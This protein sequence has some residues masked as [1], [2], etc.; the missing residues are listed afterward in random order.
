MA[1]WPS[2]RSALQLHDGLSE[3]RAAS[4]R[5]R[6]SANLWSNYRLPSPSQAPRSAFEAHRQVQQARQRLLRH[7]RPGARQGAR[8][9][10]KRASKIIKLNIG[11]LAAFG[12]EPPDEIVQDMIRNLPN[13]AGYTDSQGPVRAAQGGR[14][15]TPSK[16][17]SRASTVD[18][19]YLGN[20]ASEL[21]AM[22]MNALLND[23][24]EVL[25]PAPDYPLWTAA[26]SAVGR[27]AGA[28]PLR[29]GS[30]LDA[31]PRRHRAQDHAA[32]AR[33]RR[34]QPEQPDR[35]AVSGRRC[36]RRSSSSRASTS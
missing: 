19:V 31:R 15:T 26:V 24:D 5:A 30:R 8:R 18:D 22:S 14:C 12:F 11:N 4:F 13:A 20:G 9:W 10:R 27:H 25:I 6:G 7:P 16:S 29:R 23:G 1:F 32:H 17:T 2:I 28:L 34:H 33:D 21:I 36:C 35:R 3:W